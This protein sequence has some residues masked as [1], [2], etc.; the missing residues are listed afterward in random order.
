MWTRDGHDLVISREK[1]ERLMP[2]IREAGLHPLVERNYRGSLPRAVGHSLGQLASHARR[3][4]AWRS[5]G[6]GRRYPVFASR[7]GGLGYQIITQSLRDGRDEVVAIRPEISED[8]EMMA[9]SNRPKLQNRQSLGNAT[10][11]QNLQGVRGIY[12]IYKN[13][14]LISVGETDNLQRR[15]QQHARGLTRMGVPTTGYQIAVAPMPGSTKAQRRAEEIK[16]QQTNR[17]RGVRLTDER[18]LEALMEMLPPLAPSVR[19]GESFDL[20]RDVPDLIRALPADVKGALGQGAVNIWNARVPLVTHATQTIK[21]TARNAGR[22]INRYGRAVM[23]TMPPL[24]AHSMTQ[25]QINI[26]QGGAQSGRVARVNPNPPPQL[27]PQVPK[28]NQRPRP[29]NQPRGNPPRGQMTVRRPTG[30]RP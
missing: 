3:I 21:R 13:R 17:R 22:A 28:V 11:N 24:P 26:R 9:A 8:G 14:R 15:L 25:A 27:R 12:Q 29:T 10:S 4:G 2:Q 6:S 18:E 7:V 1:M 23:G 20:L 16:R 30:R 5:A 19:E